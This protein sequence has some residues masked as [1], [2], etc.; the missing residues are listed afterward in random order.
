MAI[1]ISQRASSQQS[2]SA[3]SG[4]NPFF[5]VKNIIIVQIPIHISITSPLRYAGTRDNPTL[6][7]FYFQS[8][9]KVPNQ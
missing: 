5:E 7:S 4:N 2:V 3:K 8:A 9:P 1:E 6:W